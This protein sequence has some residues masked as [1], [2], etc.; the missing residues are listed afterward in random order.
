MQ[1]VPSILKD[2]QKKVTHDGRS[3][4][5]SS[6]VGNT[7]SWIS[8]IGPATTTTVIAVMTIAL[9]SV[10]TRNPL[11]S[12]VAIII[13]ETGRTG[14]K[15]FLEIKSSGAARLMGKHNFKCRSDWS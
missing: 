3:L 11:K 2:Y 13:M 4:C 7:Q 6:V 10:E 12:L 14:N 5:T 8:G 9:T 1:N 15:I